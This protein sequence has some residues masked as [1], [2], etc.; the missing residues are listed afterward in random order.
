MCPFWTDIHLMLTSSTVHVPMSTSGFHH[1]VPVLPEERS[2][3]TQSAP[4][5]KCTHWCS[6]NGYPCKVKLIPHPPYSPYLSSCSWFL[7]TQI[8]KQPQRTR[9]WVSK[10]CPR[11]HKDDR[12]SRWNLLVCSFEE[13]VWADTKMCGG[14]VQS[15]L[16]VGKTDFVVGPFG[17][18]YLKTFRCPLMF[19]QIMA[20]ISHHSTFLSVVWTTFVDCQLNV[21]C[22]LTI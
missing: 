15:H 16:K 10:C 19:H 21:T 3:W 6:N 13:V 7:F 5:F 11:I 17:C 9:F 4:Q 8:K 22:I 18:E 14:S 20:Q 12:H 2:S 1:L